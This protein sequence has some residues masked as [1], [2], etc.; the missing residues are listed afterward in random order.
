MTTEIQV[1]EFIQV[2][3]I[4]GNKYRWEVNLWYVHIKQSELK[5][6]RIKMGR[7]EKQNQTSPTN[8]G[9]VYS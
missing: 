8:S 2:E 4:W 5:S 7:G 1:G 9:V 6:P 3:D